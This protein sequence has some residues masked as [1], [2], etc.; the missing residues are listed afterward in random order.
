MRNM[1]YVCG[2]STRKLVH[3]NEYKFVRFTQGLYANVWLRINS[4]T[5]T[6]F[7]RSNIGSLCTY[8]E[9]K[10]NP[11]LPSYAHHPHS[12]LLRK[13]FKKYTFINTGE[14]GRITL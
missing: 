8:F 6:T 2:N 12:L 13:L 5:F 10:S 11:L 9:H 3:K 1:V 14:G 4:R 7:V